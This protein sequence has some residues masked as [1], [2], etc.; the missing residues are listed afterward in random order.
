IYKEGQ[1]F[2][3]Y[4]AIKYGREKISEF[5]HL[6]KAKRNL[7]NAFISAFGVDVDEFNKRWIKFYQIKYWPKI[8][9]AENFD[10][11]A[12][13]VYDHKKTGSFYN[14]SPAISPNG[15]KIAFISDRQGNVELVVISSI[16]GRILKKL[17]KA[18]YSSGYEGLHLYQGG[19]TWSPDEKFVSFAAKAHGEDVLYIINARNG[20]VYK[21]FRLKLDGI[22]SPKFSP[23]GTRIIFSGLKDC[24]LD[25]YQ[26]DIKTGKT[27]KLTDD[28]Y[29]DKFPNFSSDSKIVFVSDRPD[30][31]EEYHYGSY[32]IFI[33]ND[34]SIDRI[35]PR[36]TYITSPLFYADSGLFFVADYDSAYNLYYLS[37]DHNEIV[38]KTDI[39]TGIYYPSISR[40]LQKIAFGYYNDY[41]YDICVV[42]EPLNKMVDCDTTEE[43]IAENYYEPTELEKSRV[44]N[45]RLK[46]T[47]DYIVASASYYTPLGFSGMT[48]IALSDILGDHLIQLSTDFYGSITS[49]DIFL[50]Y[51]YLKK[52]TDFGGAFYQYL[53]YFAEGNDLVIWRYLGVGGILQYPLTKFLRT[54]LGLYTYKIYE[55]RWL[56]FFDDLYS[57]RYVDTS[58]NFTYPELS[59]VFDNAK[60]G[61]TGPLNGRRAR[62][63]GYTTVFSD[64]DIKV[65]IFDYRKYFQLSPRA[66][67]ATRLVLAGNFGKDSELWSIGGP[68]SI[69]GFDY[70]TFTGGDLG[71]LNFEYR[72]PFID[73]LKLA[74]PLPM[75][76]RNIRGVLFA[77]FA[78]IYSDSFKV[79]ESADGLLPIQFKDVKMGLGFGLRFNFLFAIF[80]LDFARA[81]NLQNWI[82]ENGAP[83]HWK[84]YLTIGP[85]W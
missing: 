71:F 73:R 58:Y 84:F 47:L 44:R 82:D 35:V 78:G 24:Y 57:D 2:Y 20:R 36:T 29:A 72:F 53:N 14:T 41:G 42:K 3:N 10:N 19:I 64:F 80:K 27:E 1:A 61:D 4:V 59:L 11:F 25:I 70:Y 7:D 12:R 23:E 62:I 76:I 54:E 31:N 39:L 85:E 66:S 8:K 21:K 56:D 77:D 13:V 22:Y 38:K 37:F 63:T 50:V 15:D 9:L 18:E 60:W 26:L 32:G 48:Q 40:D 74:F 33:K 17:I 6:V 45:Y 30:S 28:I 52:R 69:R 46:F 5:I 55:T 81:N 51:W 49:S 83:S 68:G 34:E 16:D 65:G 79:Y 75:E 67:F 43:A